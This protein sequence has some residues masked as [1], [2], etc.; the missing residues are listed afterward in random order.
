MRFILLLVVLNVRFIIPSDGSDGDG[1]SNS[2]PE[3]RVSRARTRSAI[4]MSSPLSPMFLP[5]GSLS[6][7]DSEVPGVR[8]P[9]L[10]DI[11]SAPSSSSSS[12]SDSEYEKWA[13]SD[14]E[15][16]NFGR[17]YLLISNKLYGSPEFQ[18]NVYSA[19]DLN[20]QLS[21]NPAEGKTLGDLQRCLFEHQKKIDVHIRE[22]IFAL[23]GVIEENGRTR[24]SLQ[25]RQDD[26]TA[27]QDQIS[28]QQTFIH[29]Q[30]EF[31][32]QVC[33]VVKEVQQ[34][35]LDCQQEI[36]TLASLVAIMQQGQIIQKSDNPEHP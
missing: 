10:L 15:L 23:E 19:L 30:K 24:I 35:M 1:H 11:S 8:Y 34:R 22:H 27:L 18:K 31:L 29:D 2:S 6:D 33:G 3:D 13:L 28:D 14:R 16:L 25:Q 21:F 5:Q 26:I 17:L 12:H 9:Q 20:R 36:R 32:E 7:P 4:V